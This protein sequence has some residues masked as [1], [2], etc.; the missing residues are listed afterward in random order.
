MDYD[1][2]LVGAG[3]ARIEFSV[4]SEAAIEV[5]RLHHD[6]RIELQTPYVDRVTDSQS[7]TAEPVPKHST[8]VPVP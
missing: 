3:Q 2:F 6:H 7:D 5:G 1:E 8:I 4:A